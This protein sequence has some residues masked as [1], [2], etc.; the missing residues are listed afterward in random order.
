MSLEGRMALVTGAA[1]RVGRAIALELASAGC[2]LAVHYNRA[3]DEAAQLVRQVEESGRRASLIQADLT[4]PSSWE[5]VV[6]SSVEALGRLDVLVNNA[7]VFDPMPLTDFDVDAWDETMRINLTAV[8]ALCHHAEPHLRTGG[9]G[10]IVNLADIAADRP[11]PGY[12][13]YSCSKAA[14]VALTRALAV[15]LAPEVRVNAVSPGIAAF[16]DDYDKAT[17]ER[18]TAQVPLQR[19]GTPQDIAKAV[20]FLVADAPYL[21]GQITRVDGGRSVRW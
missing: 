4:E 3:A 17:R 2:D 10:C 14:L 18:L 1:R 21:T 11:F 20:R 13:A 6:S 7:S 12:L 19:A 9:R 15:E 16:P 5:R 8:T